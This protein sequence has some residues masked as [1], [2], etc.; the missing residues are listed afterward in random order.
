MV[1]SQP[2]KERQRNLIG[3]GTWQP[4]LYML[5]P[6]DAQTPESCRRCRVRSAITRGTDSMH[7][8]RGPKRCQCDPFLPLVFH[9]MYWH[10]FVSTASVTPNEMAWLSAL[11]PSEAATPNNPA[12]SKGQHQDPTSAGMEISNVATDAHIPVLSTSD[13]SR[14]S[15]STAAT[16]PLVRLRRGLGAHAVPSHVSSSRGSAI[17]FS[18]S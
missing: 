8:Y 2:T 10:M 12:R 1:K 4:G 15:P 7:M 17:A 5:L 11:A 9:A 14:A 18:S 6:G 16:A 3:P 13:T